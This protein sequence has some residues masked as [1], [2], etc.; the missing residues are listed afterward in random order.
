MDK[1]LLTEFN[2]LV[3]LGA[4]LDYRLAALYLI[5]PNATLAVL[6][7][8]WHDRTT[9]LMVED[10]GGVDPA[11]FKKTLLEKASDVAQASMP[12]L[13]TRYILERVRDSQIEEVVAA[14][15]NKHHLTVNTYPL[16]FTEAERRTLV[17]IMFEQIPIIN[18][19][20]VVS[21]SPQFITPRYLKGKHRYYVTYNFFD[22]IKLYDIELNNYPI[23]DV[24]IIAPKLYDTRPEDTLTEEE[25]KRFNDELNPWI[26]F[27]ISWGPFIGIQFEDVRWFSVITP[28]IPA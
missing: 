8:G 21:I 28:K 24:T 7:N 3:D 6:D 16:T 23:P 10:I 12:T 4:L 25:T 17:D 2:W 9:D 20:E 15:F 22:W 19:V 1:N 18:S 14:E 27:K 5:D 11:L 13:I 26:A